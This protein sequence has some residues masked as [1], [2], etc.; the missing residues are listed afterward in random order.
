MSTSISYH[1]TNVVRDIW[2]FQMT[3]ETR[4]KVF[5]GLPEQGF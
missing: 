3:I 5:I 2:H 1:T 4:I